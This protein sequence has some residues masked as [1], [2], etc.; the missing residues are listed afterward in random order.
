[1]PFEHTYGT[2]IQTIRIPFR[3]I[4]AAHGL[5]NYD[6]A[7]D[8]AVLCVRNAGDYVDQYRY[9][10]KLDTSHPNLWYHA[11]VFE[12]TAI[13]EEHYD[14]LLELLSEYDLTEFD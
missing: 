6:D 11:L 2:K 9:S 8:D 1:M 13:T 3:V 14:H 7:I 4:D 10:Y 12:I 5:E